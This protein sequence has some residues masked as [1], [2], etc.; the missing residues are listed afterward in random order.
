MLY[1]FYRLILRGGFLDGWRAIIYHILHALWYPLLIDLFYLEMRA[2]AP[3][4]RKPDGT[5]DSQAL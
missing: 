4:S 2:N 1:F 5:I 3:G